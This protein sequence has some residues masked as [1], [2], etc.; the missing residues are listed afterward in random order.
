[1]K[2][3]NLYSGEGTI[4]IMEGTKDLAVN[5]LMLIFRKMCCCKTLVSCSALAQYMLSSYNFLIFVIKL[6]VWFQVPRIE[7]RDKTYKQYRSF[8]FLFERF[9][10]YYLPHIF[11]TFCQATSLYKPN[12]G[13]IILL[14]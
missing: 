5:Y 9:K 6:C 12:L 7:W 11:P 1:M 13:K 10:Q 2:L 14:Y 4:P 8:M 3:D